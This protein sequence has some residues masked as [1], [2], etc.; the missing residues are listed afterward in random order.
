MPRRRTA[1]VANN[2]ITV[3]SQ[4]RCDILASLL[5]ERS[6]TTCGDDESP[7]PTVTTRSKRGFVTHT[8]TY[9]GVPVSI[10]MINMGY[11]NMD[12][13]VRE[14][15]AVTEGALRIVRLGSCA[16]LRPDLP[17]GTVVVASEGSI[18]I[19]QN[20]D[21]WGAEAGAGIAGDMERVEQNPY[22]FH[23]PVPSDKGLSNALVKELKRSLEGEAGGGKEG[24]AVVGCLNASTD[25]FYS[26]QGERVHVFE[27]DTAG[28]EA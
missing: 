5:D 17:V 8:G 13:L 23:R 20:P 28:L 19:S 27:R 1:A 7:A 21:A 22:V 16:G 12:F 26:S 4:S 15:R 3:G 2:I 14:I 25:S 9:K 18:F 10:V 6:D 11:P 24:P